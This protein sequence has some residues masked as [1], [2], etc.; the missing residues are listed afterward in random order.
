M[1]T[2]A[3]IVLATGN[4]HKVEEMTSLLQSL[5]DKFQIVGADAVGGMP[6]V[7]ENADNFEGNALIKAQAL[8]S[9]TTGQ[10]WV[11]ADD[12]GLE[13][14]VL[15]GAPGIYSAR[16]AGSGSSDKD[17]LD[18]LLKV[19]EKIPDGKRSARF[20]CALSLMEP[21]GKSYQ[22]RG[23]CHGRILM[24]AQGNSGFGYDPVFC[25]DGYSQSIAVLGVS[26][27]EQISHRARAIAALRAFLGDQ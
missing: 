1:A 15:A 17:N 22:F 4:A 20:V 3:K 25:P 2:I 14:D 21:G 23:E 18:K 24:E 6:E 7:E 9:I 27:K 5:S 19:L 10:M 12:S 26:V 8:H 11:L 13:V 16:F